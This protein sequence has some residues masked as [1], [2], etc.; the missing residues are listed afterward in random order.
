MDEATLLHS[1][2]ITADGVGTVTAVAQQLD[3]GHTSPEGVEE[4]AYTK[5]DLV[6]NVQAQEVDS[7]DE[8]YLIIFQLANATNFATATAVHDRAIFPVGYVVYGTNADVWTAADLGQVVLG[9]DNYMFGTL[10]RFA[11]VLHMVPAGT[12][13][14]GLDYDAYFCERK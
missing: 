8:N 1:G 14:T 2:A 11:R 12:I 9:V 7:T 3:F 6:I 13:A 10:Y 5:G 4:I